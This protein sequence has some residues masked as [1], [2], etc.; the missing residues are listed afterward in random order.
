MIM[1]NSLIENYSIASNTTQ[2]ETKTKTQ[3]QTQT[4]TQIEEELKSLSIETP[5]HDLL[6]NNINKDLSESVI[7]D[8]LE[9]PE[10]K[11][12]TSTEETDNVNSE[13]PVVTLVLN[14]KTTIEERDT[15]KEDLL[16]P[17]QYSD[18]VS[19]LPLDNTTNDVLETTD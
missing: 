15:T 18:T 19:T 11:I 9:A 7:N 3:T 8:T 16:L 17:E 4:Q 5:D 10:L 13:E 2:T 6:V 14:N 12:S 1:H